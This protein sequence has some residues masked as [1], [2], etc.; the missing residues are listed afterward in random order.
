MKKRTL[1]H[2]E[3]YK[4]QLKTKCKNT[5]PNYFSKTHI[6]DFF[7]A[8]GSKTVSVLHVM[9]NNNDMTHFPSLWSNSGSKDG[10]AKTK[11]STLIGLHLS[12]ASV[13]PIVDDA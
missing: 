10:R 1:L 13:D 7:N 4:S 8:N 5:T 9:S 11:H 2:A 6:T 3:K 12:L